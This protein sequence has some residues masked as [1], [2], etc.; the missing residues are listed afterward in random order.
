MLKNKI[1]EKMIESMKAK[2]AQ[3]TSVYRMLYSQIKNVEIDK[4][5]DLIDEEV[6][7][8]IKKQIVQLKDAAEMF[9]SG[10]RPELASEN[11]QQIAILSEFLPPEVSDDEI[12]Q[13]IKKL[14]EEKKDIFD[15]NPKAFTGICVGALKNK[16]DSK[17]I[18]TL[19]NEI[20]NQ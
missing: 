1:Q 16:A 8:I 14:L 5:Q 11:N 13:D 2:E 10:G 18:V 20:T 4:R 15:K 7:Q 6:I 3:K 17:R 12:R 9:I 19:F